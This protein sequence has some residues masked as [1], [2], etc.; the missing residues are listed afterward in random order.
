MK[1]IPKILIAVVL[2]F[3]I[4]GTII[5]SLG[6]SLLHNPDN[7]VEL[8]SSQSLDEK[9]HKSI[10]DYFNEQY[11]TTAV[12]A[13]IYTD[14]ITVDWVR[15][16]MEN[17]IKHTYSNLGNKDAEYKPDY[18]GLEESISAFFSDYA[19]SINYNPD[20]AYE[21]KLN[22]TIEK[23]ESSIN[24]KLDVFK[25]ETMRKAGILNKIDKII[26]LLNAGRIISGIASVI[27]IIVLILGKKN[28]W[29]RIYWT[30]CSFFSVGLI[31][32]IPGIFL[33]ATDYFSAFTIK[34]SA[35][36]SAFTGIMNNT[37]NTILYSGIVCA[38]IGIIAI[39]S[40]FFKKKN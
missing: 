13:K 30:G 12:P 10:E 39:V 6:Y 7:C 36:Y 11:N 22:E 9:A 38:A 21:K 19:K 31:L 17:N 33:I 34:D 32:M 15:K 3:C 24:S 28:V 20:E 25:F 2:N 8:I 4:L 37:T 29:G 16:E 18:T 5:C 26:P 1:I 14:I 23:A 40:G 27:L 35:I